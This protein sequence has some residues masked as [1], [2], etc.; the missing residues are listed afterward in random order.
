MDQVRV[1]GAWVVDWAGEVPRKKR[2]R[3]AMPISDEAAEEE[4]ARS[5]QCS[6]EDEEEKV[7]SG[8]WNGATKTQ[9]ISV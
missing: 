2:R 1:R 3:L 7:G 5:A 9:S 6:S 8:S 4:P